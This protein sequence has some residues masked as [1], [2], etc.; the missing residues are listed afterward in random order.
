MWRMKHESR[1]FIQR[2]QLG[3]I[4]RGAVSTLILLY[5][6]NSPILH[7]VMFASPMLSSR[8]YPSRTVL[9]LVKLF[10]DRVLE[11]GTGNAPQGRNLNTC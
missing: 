10:N 2:P 7:D 8:Y 5:S 4:E 9:P 3:Q 11:H 6:R 1:S